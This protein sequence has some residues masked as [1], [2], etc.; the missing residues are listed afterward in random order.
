MA[1]IGRPT[2]AGFLDHL[3]AAGMSQGPPSPGGMVVAPWGLAAFEG[4]EVP[5]PG[6]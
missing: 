6:P 3:L 1:L 5:K 4:R 2:R